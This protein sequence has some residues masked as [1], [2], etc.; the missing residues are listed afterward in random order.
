[1][2][3]W[4]WRFFFILI[5]VFIQKIMQPPSYFSISVQPLSPPLASLISAADQHINSARTRTWACSIEHVQSD[6]SGTPS[7]K[8]EF[9]LNFKISNRRWQ[10]TRRYCWVPTNPQ[11]VVCFQKTWEV[12]LKTVLTH[13]TGPWKIW[14]NQVHTWL[15]DMKTHSCLQSYV[16]EIFYKHFQMLV[17]NFAKRLPFT[18]SEIVGSWL[19]EVFLHLYCISHTS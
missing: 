14:I 13:L 4:K 2:A 18:T 5:F 9:L 19:C 10:G 3:K 11:N 15:H 1:M 12:N 8:F 16:F 7:T 6:S 17:V